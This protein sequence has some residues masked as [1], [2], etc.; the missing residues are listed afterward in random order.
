MRLLLVFTFLLN[1]LPTPSSARTR[2]AFLK[3]YQNGKLVQYE[4]GGRFSHTAIQFD[5]I[6]DQWLNA[7]P[8]EGV[9]VISL[10][11][12]R[13]HG[14][15]AEIIEIPHTLTLAQV[16]PYLGLPFDFWYSWDDRAIYCSELIGKLLAVPTHPMKFNRAVWPKNYWKLDGTPGLSPDA[17]YRWA[18]S[19]AVID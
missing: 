9:A 14:V 3:F 19:V 15:V 11:R 10:A 6:G 7:Y 16:Q 8:E 2:I 5:D 1:F 18:K 13:Q 4:E 12:L 17:L